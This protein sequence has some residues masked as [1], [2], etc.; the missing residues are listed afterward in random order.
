MH[1]PLTT[2]GG[3]GKV[4]QAAQH[5]RQVAPLAFQAFAA[6]GAPRQ[7]DET[8]EKF[9]TDLTM[10]LDKVGTL[11]KSVDDKNNKNLPEPFCVMKCQVVY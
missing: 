10:K 9:T 4:L 2:F 6:T 5:Q 1:L 11:D 8:L 7:H 3:F